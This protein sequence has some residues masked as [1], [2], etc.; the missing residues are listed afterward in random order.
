MGV[1]CGGEE[2]VSQIEDLRRCLLMPKTTQIFV[3][4]FLRKG[5]EDT[6]SSGNAM[7]S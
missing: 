7:R 3:N 5:D 1:P 4:L 2:A 6:I